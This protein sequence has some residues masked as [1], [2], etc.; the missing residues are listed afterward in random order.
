MNTNIFNII[1]K[2]LVIWLLPKP[3]RKPV[4]VS[5]IMALLSP[6]TMFYNLFLAFRTSV[7]YLLDIDSTISKLQ[8]LLNDRYDSQQRRIVIV[9]GAEFEP[10]F[11]YQRGENKPVFLY[12]KSENKPV[13]LYTKAEVGATTVDFVINIPV[14]VVADVSEVQAL[15]RRFK[16]PGK[17]FKVQIV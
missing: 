15:I 14:F 17:T 6:L 13:Y 7:L 2:K 16:L 4:Q 5:W 1:Y 8:K 10:V 11:I 12:Q 3:I 9:D